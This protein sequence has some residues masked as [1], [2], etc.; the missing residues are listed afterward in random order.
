MQ[1]T[2]DNYIISFVDRDN[3]KKE[4]LFYNE[5]ANFYDRRKS[6]ISI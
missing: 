1:D 6:A 3:G 2:V 5:D 4:I